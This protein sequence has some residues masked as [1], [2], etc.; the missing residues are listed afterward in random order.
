MSY[1][2]LDI[3]DLEITKAK[4]RESFLQQEKCIDQI[5]DSITVNQSV[6]AKTRRVFAVDSGY[7][8]AYETTFVLFKA[9]VVDEE[10]EVD[11]SEDIYL[12]HVDNYQTD[13]LKRLL[14]QQSLYQALFK[15]VQSGR[16]DGS[17]VLVDGTIT[18]GLFIPTPRDRREYRMHFKNFYEELYTTL[19][20]QCLKR[21]ILVLGFLKRTGSNY[22]AE[23]LRLRGTYDIYIINALLREQGQN[24]G[25][26]PVPNT[27]SDSAR[28]IQKYVTFY[29]NLKG[30]N[31]RFELLREQEQY[32]QECM[33]NLLYI[34][35]DAH[36][37]MNP[38]FSKADEYARVAKREANLKF[39][40]IIHDLDTE[41]RTRMR[42]EARR[43]THF[44]YNMA[45]V[46]GRMPSR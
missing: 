23:H 44:G 32:Y 19:M 1:I 15:T 17:M 40:Y 5:K 2:R 18:L 12:F 46:P 7:N 26:I 16:A 42:L 43:R 28:I 24:I 31:Y 38:T 27:S 8:S 29:L 14:M 9:A 13:R 20:E 36:C 41:E 10:M 33:E 21:N 35:T 3:D 22:L 25:P 11:R 39:D 34:A 37:G 6:Q 30:W 45:K 4:F